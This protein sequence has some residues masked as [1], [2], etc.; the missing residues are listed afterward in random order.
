MNSEP[1]KKCGLT[2]RYIKGEFSYCRPCHSEAQK[3]YLQR[4]AMGESVE[5]LRPPNIPLHQQ[6]FSKKTKRVCKNGHLLS[7]DNVRTSSQ[8]R[9]RHYRLMCRTCER[10]AKRVR[11]GLAAEPAGA[12]L[13]ELLD[14]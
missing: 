2:D 5:L 14:S 11:Y 13:S 3:R 1:C 9:G 4:K 12:T 8:R 10:N 7:G 6:N